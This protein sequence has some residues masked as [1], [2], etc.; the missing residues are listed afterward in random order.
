MLEA[1][2]ALSAA[3]ICYMLHVIGNELFCMGSVLYHAL[4]ED[5]ED[6]INRIRKRD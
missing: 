6:V 2:I 3:G 4:H 1:V 5:D